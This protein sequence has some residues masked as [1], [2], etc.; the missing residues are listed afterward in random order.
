MEARGLRLNLDLPEP[1]LLVRADPRRL[2]QVLLN[3]LSN[4]IKYN[5]PEGQITLTHQT[6]A[7][8]I[9]LIVEDTGLGIDKARQD[10]LF[11]PF[12]RLGQENSAIQ[13]TG[14][15]LSLC[16]QFASLMGGSMGVSSEPGIG[17]SF[18]IELPL[19]PDGAAGYAPGGAPETA[20]R[21]FYVEDNPSSQ[22]LVRKALAGLG[23][24]SVIDS[25]KA[26]LERILASPPDLLLLDLNL[27]D[28]GGERVLEI[29]RR[30]PA[31]RS[32]PVVVLSAV[33][34]AERLVRLDCQGLLGKPLNLDELRER[35]AA[36]LPHARSAHA[37]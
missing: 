29:L 31:T 19:V 7:G 36:L 8:H 5:T 13:G 1:G 11:E 28:L 10:Q 21:I 17:S 34:D 26:A 30:H 6:A 35:V 14:I 37:L 4:A 33:A 12:Q 16:R 23:E 32:L 25:G 3:L 15:G 22:F 20:A 9:R 24:V 2:R 18:W 27:P